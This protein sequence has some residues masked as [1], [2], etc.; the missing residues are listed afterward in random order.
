MEWNSNEKENHDDG[1][2]VTTWE[3]L[4]STNSLIDVARLHCNIELEQDKLMPHYF[5]ARTRI[6]RG[7]VDRFG[8]ECDGDGK[9]EE[10]G[11]ISVVGAYGLDVEKGR[12]FEVC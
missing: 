6:S 12:K 7:E 10:A 3:S 4:T 1:H 2:K 9:D 8:D 5:L 11:E